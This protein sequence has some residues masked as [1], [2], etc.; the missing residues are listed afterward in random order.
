VGEASDGMQLLEIIKDTTPDMVIVDIS[1]P[2][3]R[4]IEAIR[5]I[6]A[7]YADIKL[8]FISMHENRE[9]LNYAMDNGA[10]GFIFKLNLDMELCPAIGSIRCGEIYISPLVSK[11]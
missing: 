2:S 10:D 6:R 8:I 9:Y 7:I 1:M 11:G 3:L 5:I 4:D